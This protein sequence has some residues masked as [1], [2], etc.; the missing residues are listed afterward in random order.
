[1]GL[2]TLRSQDGQGSEAP[3]SA[4]TGQVVE[5]RT[6]ADKPKEQG[7][8]EEAKEG[9]NTSESDGDDEDDDDHNLARLIAPRQN[10]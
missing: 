5:A 8:N 2:A 7:N 1:M 9:D 10:N 3:P 6:N 4:S